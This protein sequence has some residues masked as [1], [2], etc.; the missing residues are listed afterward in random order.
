MNEPPVSIIVAVKNA[1]KTIEKCIDSILNVDYAAFEIIVVDDGSTDFTGQILKKYSGKIMY[2]ANPACLGP[3]K[4]RNMA[5]ELSRGSFLAFTDAD[6]IVNRSWLKELLAGFNETGVV[7]A[8]GRQDIPENETF[9]GRKVAHFMKKTGFLSDYA[10]PHA[11]GVMAV[12]H[13]ASCNV[14]YKKDIFLN[15][16]GFLEGLWPGEDV[17]LDYRLKKKGYRLN[18]NPKAV[19]KH[20]RPASLKAFVKMM[21]RYGYAQGFLVRRHGFFRKIQLIPFVFTGFVL[22]FIFLALGHLSMAWV[23]LGAT[24]FTFGLWLGLDF[25]IFIMFIAAFLSWNA[26]FLKGVCRAPRAKK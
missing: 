19:V 3:A 6:C 12:N 17:E 22:L 25:S 10:R 21:Y 16:G 1:Q 9:F 23:L 4:S 15:V 14:M 26:G 11:Y 18:C 7:S 13:N 20:Y 8:G 2:L 5:A 24:F